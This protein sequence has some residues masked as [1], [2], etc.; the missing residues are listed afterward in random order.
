MATLQYW[1]RLCPLCGRLLQK[2]SRESAWKC[3][4]CD[5]T[6]EDVSRGHHWDGVSQ[7]TKSL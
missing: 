3:W 4:N 5:W 7:K 1:S 2:E 6:T